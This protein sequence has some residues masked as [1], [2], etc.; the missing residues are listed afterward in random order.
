MRPLF[1]LS[2]SLFS[3]WD[4]LRYLQSLSTRHLALH[5]TPAVHR[6]PRQAFL[7][8]AWKYLTHFLSDI[9]PA[10]NLLYNLR[11]HLSKILEL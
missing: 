3:P 11:C 2:V 8:D 7:W 10:F 4:L 6:P 1:A 9:K 5:R